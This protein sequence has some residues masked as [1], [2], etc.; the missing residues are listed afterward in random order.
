VAAGGF[1]ALSFWFCRVHLDGWFSFDVHSQIKSVK[2]RLLA[3]TYEP[4][5]QDLKKDQIYFEAYKVLVAPEPTSLPGVV[6]TNTRVHS[7]NVKLL[8]SC[9]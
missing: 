5:Q 7:L 6:K 8:L 2:I 4:V 1:A 3:A 9:K